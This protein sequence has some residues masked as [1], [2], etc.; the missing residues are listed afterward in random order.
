MLKL[1]YF[2]LD[3]TLPSVMADFGNLQLE[4]DW[5]LNQYNLST[6]EESGGLVTYT[7]IVYIEFLPIDW[8]TLPGKIQRG[9]LR[10]NLHLVTESVHIDKRN[11]LLPDLSGD[12]NTTLRFKT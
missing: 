9:L 2:F 4:H 6:S 1:Y 11:F 7:P 5:F 3:I 10:F 8:K 12:M